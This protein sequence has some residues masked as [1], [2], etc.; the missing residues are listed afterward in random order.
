[1]GDQDI[2]SY[3]EKFNISL[4]V[5]NFEDIW[6]RKIDQKRQWNKIIWDL[7]NMTLIADIA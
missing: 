2:E 4:V 6:N 3:I 5:D 1:M 7:Y